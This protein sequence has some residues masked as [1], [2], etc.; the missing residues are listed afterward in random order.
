MAP[1]DRSDRCSRSN[2]CNINTER[3]KGH[4][5]TIFRDEYLQLLGILR[6]AREKRRLS[7]AELGMLVGQ[8]QTFVSKY[9]NGVRR[10]DFLETLDICRTLEIDIH[11]LIE[12]LENGNRSIP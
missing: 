8:D 11:I 2:D 1:S 3:N 9:E 5:K 6:S 4:P 12:E 10:L 7:Q